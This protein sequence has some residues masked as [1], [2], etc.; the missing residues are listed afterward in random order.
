MDR[1]YYTV[2]VMVYIRLLLGVDHSYVNIFDTGG[3]KE[4]WFAHEE[5]AVA[6]KLK[7]KCET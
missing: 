7:F 2:E 4:I 1:Y 5:D 3:Y 6:F